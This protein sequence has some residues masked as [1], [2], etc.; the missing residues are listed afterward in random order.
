MQRKSNATI[1]LWTG[2]VLIVAHA[3][4][5]MAALVV[6]VIA[7]GQV[8]SS[9]DL[10][11]NSIVSGYNF[12]VEFASEMVN[13]SAS[14]LS[15]VIAFNAAASVAWLVVAVLLASRSRFAIPI[16]FVLIAVLLSHAAALYGLSYLGPPTI[17]AILFYAFV[18]YIF[19]RR[20]VR[21]LFLAQHA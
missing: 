8:T 3:I 6:S 12:Y 21:A 10:S 20:D 11:L 7:F 2:I 5:K 9:P 13:T 14:F 19:L 15:Y 4:F 18:R 17:S 1:A 16:L